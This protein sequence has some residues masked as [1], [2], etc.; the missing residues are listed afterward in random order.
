M[1]EIEIKILDVNQ[2]EIEDKIASSGA[3]KVADELIIEKYYDF[4]ELDIAK[5][6]R[7]WF[8]RF[9]HETTINYILRL[10]SLSGFPSKRLHKHIGMQLKTRLRKRVEKNRASISSAL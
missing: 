7:K 5:V 6:K 8:G 4:E 2:K 9:K 1:K 3:K 10:V